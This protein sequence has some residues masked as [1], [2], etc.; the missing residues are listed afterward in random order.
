MV[1]LLRTLAA[2]VGLAVAVG[3]AARRVPL[4]EA[5]DAA[6][7]AAITEWFE[8]A[9]WS[10]HLRQHARLTAADVPVQEAVRSFHRGDGPPAVSHLLPLA[11]RG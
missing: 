8:V 9:T 6:D 5:E 1:P 2:A 3:L 11:A 4:P 7:P 10:A